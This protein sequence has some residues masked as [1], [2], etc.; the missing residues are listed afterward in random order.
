MSAFPLQ[1]V[2][3]GKLFSVIQ[4]QYVFSSDPALSVLL[5]AICGKVNGVLYKLAHL[6]L[7]KK[8]QFQF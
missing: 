7:Q 2:D 1:P 5:H 4:K 6:I 3:G 8:M